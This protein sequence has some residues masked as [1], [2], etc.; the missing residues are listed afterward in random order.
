[1][2][3]PVPTSGLVPHSPLAL[4]E[5]L[6]TRAKA[7]RVVFFDVDG[8][9]TDGKLYYKDREISFKTNDITRK[10]LEAA[11]K[12]LPEG[13]SG[14][15]FS[16]NTKINSLY[17][18]DDGKVYL[19]LNKEFITEMNA[20]SGYEEMLLQCIANTFGSYYGVDKV[21][22]TIDNHLYESGHIKLEKGQYLSVKTEGSVEIP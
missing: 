12:E 21:I 10:A 13:I 15:V 3:L 7:V 16:D 6:L 17:L 9:L 2:N 4:P 11:Y 5:T 8:V 22:L 14:K 19:D 18:N 20:D 1:M